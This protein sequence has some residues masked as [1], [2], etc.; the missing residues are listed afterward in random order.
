LCAAEL[1]PEFVEA[2]YNAGSVLLGMNRLDEALH[3]YEMVASLR[4][5]L[6]EAH[7]M[8][9]KLA[10]AYARTGNI[11]QAAAIA[12]RALQLAQ[13]ARETDLAGRLTADLQSYRQEK[14]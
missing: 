14:K 1:Q 3:Q 2:H 6:R 4:P 9:G 10:A 8:L 11:T 7:F 13:A 5:Q 12:Q